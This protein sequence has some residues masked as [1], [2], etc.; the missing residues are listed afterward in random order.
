MS[1]L[2]TREEYGAIAKGLTLPVNAFIDGSFRPA[3]SW[4][5]YSTSNSVSCAQ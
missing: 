1:D 4:S 3:H 5:R 2:L